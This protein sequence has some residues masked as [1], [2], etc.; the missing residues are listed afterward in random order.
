MQ[1]RVEQKGD[2][3]SHA[4]LV[5]GLHDGNDSAEQ[6]RAGVEAMTE[7]SATPAEVASRR[8][9]DPLQR[10]F[11]PSAQYGYVVG[12]STPAPCESTVCLLPL[13]TT[14]PMYVQARVQ[15]GAR[16]SVPDR[17]MHRCAMMGDMPILHVNLA[18]TVAGC[19]NPGS[20]AVRTGRL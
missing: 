17:I 3:P 1:R 12:L 6:N 8:M 16:S 2:V 9:F 15:C 14:Y 5:Q 13:R 18:S 20:V 10:H 19:S 11:A 7:D 4:A